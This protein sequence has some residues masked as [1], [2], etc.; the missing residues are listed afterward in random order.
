M[1]DCIV[2]VCLYIY[3]CVCENMYESKEVLWD[4]SN[5]RDVYE[6]WWWKGKCVDLDLS[7]NDVYD[8][9]HP[10]DSTHR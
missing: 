2:A 9:S 8:G 6:L 5:G 7:C 10:P 1:D 4:A 3:M